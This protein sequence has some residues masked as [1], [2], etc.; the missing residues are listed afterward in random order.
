VVDPG[1]DQ[2]VLAPQVLQRLSLPLD[3]RGDVLQAEAE[4]AVGEHRVQPI[5][6]RLVVEAVTGGGSSARAHE[7][8]LVV[9]VQGPHRH[10]GQPRDRPHR[11]EL[12]GPRPGHDIDARG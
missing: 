6:V 4:L 2:G 5:E 3:Q 7:P 12:V 11:Q 1:A 8:D 10:A 9:V